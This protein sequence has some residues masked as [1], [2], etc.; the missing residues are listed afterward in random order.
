M[1]TGLLLVQYTDGGMVRAGVRHDGVVRALPRNWPDT[2]L[3]ILDA[4]D[5]WDGQLRALDPRALPAV[6]G[7]RLAAPVTFPR[8]VLCAGAN[9]YS[10]A[11]EM[12]TARPDPRAAPFFFLKPPT[13]TIGGPVTSVPLPRGEAP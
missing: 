1:T 7:A 10:H 11:E 6:P 5:E 12:G 9:Y 13:T 2:V 4:W 3:G 8:K